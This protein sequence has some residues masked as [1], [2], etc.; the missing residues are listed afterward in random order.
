VGSS[1]GEGVG[2]S[3]K[4]AEFA[5]G[6]GVGTDYNFFSMNFLLFLFFPPQKIWFFFNQGEK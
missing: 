5:P 4:L 1:S 6:S 3:A 2:E